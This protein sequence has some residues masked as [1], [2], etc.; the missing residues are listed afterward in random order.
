MKNELYDAFKAK[1]ARFDGRFF[2]GVSS[3]GIYCRPTCRA[4]LPMAKNCSYYSSAAAAESAG[5]RP[6]LIC[7]P[8]LAPGIPYTYA[9]EMLAHKAARMIE[10]DCNASLVSIAERLGCTDRH[11]R[12]TFSKE[13]GVSPIEYAQTCRLL[14]AK[15]IL[16]ETNLSMPEVASA[17]GFGST[18]RFNSLFL[19]QYSI[20]PTA[21]RKQASKGL[22]SDSKISLSLGYRPPYLWNDIL[23][24]LSYRAIKGVEKVTDETYHRTVSLKTRE[25][26]NVQGWLSVRNE[27]KRNSLKVTTSAS[28]IPILS[29]VLS[30]IRTLFDLYCDPETVYEGL[31][32]MNSIRNGIYVKGTRIPGCFDPFEMSVR[33]VLGQ[34]IT[35]KAASTLAS[36]MAEKYGKPIQTDVEGLTHIFPSAWDI[37]ELDGPL[38]DHLGP[39]GITSQKS[40]TISKLATAIEHRI[41]DF[42]ICASP[43][44]EMTKLMEIPGIGKWTAQY[45]AMRAMGWTDAFLDTDLGIKKAMSPLTPK[46]MVDTAEAWAPWRSYATI[47]L[48][49]SLK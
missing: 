21:L 43:E 7:R 5:F 32:S 13:Y 17:A 27:P 37:L 38:A 3:T 47:N 40:N 24:F 23:D 26:G 36:R 30:R 46:E 19:K 42:G 49:N 15:N 10:E 11:L 8:E 31:E 44:N 4:K 33:C 41:I 20:S 14:L 6:C 35:V 34:Q 16:T 45:I 1:D 2:V 25:H 39:L 18:R 28:L 29:Q 22:D 9:T 48:W 12:R